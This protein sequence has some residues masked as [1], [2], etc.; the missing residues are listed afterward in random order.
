VGE[1]ED[2]EVLV[3]VVVG[4]AEAEEGVV[5]RMVRGMR[6]RMIS[7]NVFLWVLRGMRTWMTLI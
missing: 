5:R 6:S 7:M 1:E 3:E 2:V 4:L